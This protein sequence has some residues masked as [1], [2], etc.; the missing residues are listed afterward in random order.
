MK[1][2]V[3]IIRFFFSPAWDIVISREGSWVNTGYNDD[4]LKSGE[5]IIRKK[6][7]HQKSDCRAE[8]LQKIAHNKKRL[9]AKG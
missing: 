5:I 8:T 1:K 2:L 4:E 3:E 7:K 9:Y 6:I